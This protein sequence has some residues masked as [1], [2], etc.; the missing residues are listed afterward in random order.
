MTRLRL[1]LAL[2]LLLPLS[3][4]T[5]VPPMA[6]THG[7]PEAVAS[8]VLDAVAKG[9]RKA[10]DLLALDER[11]FKDHVWPDLPAARPERN[12]PFSYVWMDLH[13]KSNIALARTIARHGGTRYELKAVTFAGET[14]YASYRVH[15]DATFQVSDSSGM[16]LELRVC[17]SMIEKDGT[18]KVFSYVVD[19]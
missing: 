10:L 13:Q 11:E 12:L 16:P 19:D 8:A 6:N 1:V 7:S 2:P 18:W 17:G 15:R 3:G 14:P 9:D 5:R 4:C